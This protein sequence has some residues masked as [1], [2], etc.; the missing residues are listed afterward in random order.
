MMKVNVRVLFYKR[1]NGIISRLIKWWTNSDYYHVEM[2]IND[3]RIS[4][5]YEEGVKV[6]WTGDQSLYGPSD[7]SYELECELTNK[8]YRIIH[9]W[10]TNVNNRNYDLTGIFLSQI[11]RSRVDDPKRWF[12]SELVTKVLQL[13]LV[14]EVISLTPNM[15]SP[16]DLAKL[17]KVEEI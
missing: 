10:L 13:L 17:F 7:D 8:Q 4:S 16:G 1:A 6:S 3:T 2:T 14:E 9:T 5:T 11:L 15:I 12:C